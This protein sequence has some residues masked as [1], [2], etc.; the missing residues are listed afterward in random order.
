[1]ITKETQVSI[2]L[3]TRNGAKT[4][5]RALDS[6]LSQTFSD[7]ELIIS[8]N[9]S[10][11]EIPHICKE[12]AAKDSRIRYIRQDKSLSAAENQTFV[13]CEAQGEYFMWASDD[14]IW[15]PN[16]IEVLLTKLKNNPE[17]DVAMG[18]YDVL[19]SNGNLK[20]KV[21]FSGDLD[22][23][24]QTHE[25]VF[26]KMLFDSPIH[27]FIYGL[28][29]KNFILK[30]MRRFPSCARPDRVMMCEVALASKFYSVEPTLFFK[31]CAD[32]PLVRRDNYQGDPMRKAFAGRFAN[33]RY[34]LTLPFWL[35]SSRVIPF[36]HKRHILPQWFRLLWRHKRLIFNESL[37]AFK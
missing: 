16:F 14:D 15:A 36:V 19:W 22:T 3:F 6:L 26:K 17:Y 34:F 21:V 31:V 25:E 10:T 30:V 1:M 9:V 13:L 27:V 32:T 11:D 28:Y 4:I 24:H 29:R 23:V 12:Y 7:F 8:D 37:K 33:T 20:Y 5:K 35:V 18:S 2:G